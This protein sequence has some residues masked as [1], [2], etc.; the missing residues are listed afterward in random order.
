MKGFCHVFV[1]TFAFVLGGCSSETTLILM[2]DQNGHVGAIT[3]K[4]DGDFRVVDQAYESAVL[5]SGTSRLTLSAPLSNTEIGREYQR[6]LQAE[7]K[8]ST[9]FMLY[10]KVGSTGLVRSSRLRI[11]ELIERIKSRLPTEITLI[12]HTDTTGTNEYN[13]RLS[14]R[15][16]Q[17]VEK[18]LRSRLPALDV[19][20][21]QY[22]GAQKL[23]IPTAP[24]IEEQRNRV[25][26]VL[27]L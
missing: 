14:L 22:Y 8:P 15:R 19:I 13:N 3:V 2:P 6:L 1:L 16:A 5:K 27:I 7:P 24:N 18:L 11:P 17:A 4:T 26:E 10:F 12:G 9:S 20:N 23:L 25:V 21:V